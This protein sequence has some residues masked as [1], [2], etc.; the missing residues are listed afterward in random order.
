VTEESAIPE[1]P[2]A[3]IEPS[4]L[5]EV[6]TPRGSEE[7]KNGLRI[8]TIARSESDLLKD[9]E[10]ENPVKMNGKGPAVADDTM[11][12]IEI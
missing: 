2:S 5:V 4:N 6:E 10:N 8:S 1:I 11:K 9:K 7:G 12:T 3:E